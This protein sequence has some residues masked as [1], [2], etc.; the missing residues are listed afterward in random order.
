MRIVEVAEAGVTIELDT[1]DLALLAYACDHA[2]NPMDREPFP[3]Q[4]L[5]TAATLFESCEMIVRMRGASHEADRERF[6]FAN[7]RAGVV[8]LRAWRNRESNAAS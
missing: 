2:A 4:E 3:Y 6:T 1:H 7:L 5:E 8:D